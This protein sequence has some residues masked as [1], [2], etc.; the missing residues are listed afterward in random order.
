MKTKFDKF[1]TKA[2]S[3]NKLSD[4][5]WIKNTHPDLTTLTQD[6]KMKTWERLSDT[7]KKLIDLE[8]KT[9]N[10]TVITFVLNLKFKDCKYPLTKK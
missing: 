1:K 6:V 10:L 4:R 7:D 5:T 3:E 9:Q 8:T 2:E